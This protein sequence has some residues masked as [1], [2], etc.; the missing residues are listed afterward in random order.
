MKTRPSKLK[1]FLKAM[2]LV[3][4]DERSVILTD[5]ELLVA[6]NHR[7]IK[8]NRVGISTFESWKSPTSTNLDDQ[9][10]S[11]AALI[12]DFRETLAYARVNQKL[13][14][15]GNLLDPQNRNGWGAKTLLEWKFKDLQQNQVVQIGMGAITLNIEGGDAK[16]LDT[17]DIDYE[18]ID[19]LKIK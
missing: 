8:R 6:V 5:Q 2:K 3:L 16:L 1:N 9:V 17:I 18:D 14:L 15:T 13:G 4:E 11:D 10:N 12:A 7:L 19:Q